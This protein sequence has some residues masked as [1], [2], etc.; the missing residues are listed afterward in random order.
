MSLS[1]LIE[2]ARQ[3]LHETL[4]DFDRQPSVS[5]LQDL[6]MAAQIFEL[7]YPPPADQTLPSNAAQAD[8]RN[9]DGWAVHKPS[10]RAL[11]D[12]AL[13]WLRRGL[14]EDI[15]V[16]ETNQAVPAAILVHMAKQAHGFKADDL[17]ALTELTR[18]RL[19]GGHE[20][21]ALL[22]VLFSACTGRDGAD[23]DGIADPFRPSD[24]DWRPLQ[25][26]PLAHELDTLIHIAFVRSVLKA[27]QPFGRLVLANTL[28]VEA[29][30]HGDWNSAALLAFLACDWLTF[31][32]Y[33]GDRLRGVAAMAAQGTPIDLTPWDTGDD[34]PSGSAEGRRM[35]A[36]LA[37]TL[38]PAAARRI[39][40]DGTPGPETDH[41]MPEPAA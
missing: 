21:T 24:M 12:A 17:A 27:R 40:V 36:A 29:L 11:R 3:T 8:G 1:P 34:M 26:R 14:F 33:A 41:K 4:R 35:R 20:T 39:S 38:I 23:R 18:H 22:D 25:G 28:A 6:A 16:C 10:V 37:L 31:P 5:G 32:H 30:R 13:A 7:G 15:F 2:Q 19:I 9:T